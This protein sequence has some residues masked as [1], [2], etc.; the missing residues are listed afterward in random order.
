MLY[1]PVVKLYYEENGLNNTQLFLLHGIYSVIIAVSEIPSGYAADVW[2][3]KK[4]MIVGLFFGFLGFAFYSVTYGFWGFLMAEVLLG[5]GEGFTSGCDTALLYDSLQQQHKQK[6][7]V[8]HEGRIT[9]VGNLSEA[10]AGIIVTILAFSVMRNYYYIQTVIALAGLVTAFFLIEPSVHHQ[11][12]IERNWNHII[13]I[14]KQSLWKDKLLSYT[15]I[16]SSVIG[17]ASLSMAW[18]A[19]IFLYKAG[20]PVRYFGITWTYL[21]LVVA[22]GSFTSF[23]VY[24]KLG[25]KT[26]LIFL[27]VLISGGFLL[28]SQSISIYGI[29]LLTLFYF[30]R[31]VAHPVLKDRI[32]ALTKSHVRATVLSIRS[33]VI[34][35]L[36][37]ALGPLLGWVTDKFSLSTALIFCGITILM[38]GL[39]LLP[40][41]IK[42]GSSHR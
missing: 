16:F 15:I 8:K 35:I 2:G 36:F 38:P 23:W 41:I 18:F 4:S 20:L 3:R 28:A 6:E 13:E 14:V 32:N 40:F 11:D 9:S 12:G 31:G 26:T 25:L 30:V 33:F 24:H 10:L 29:L 5:I 27:L 34:R 21:N 7:Y 42:N 37:F 39:F 22:A 17:F 1:M 19:Q